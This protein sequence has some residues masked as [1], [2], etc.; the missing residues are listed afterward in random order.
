[1]AHF[2]LMT[3]GVSLLAKSFS[4]L[5]CT[6]SL[7]RCTSVHPVSFFLTS[8]G[9]TAQAGGPPKRP[10][11]GYMRYVV[12]QQPTIV[13]QNPA[14]KIT[15][16]IRKIAQEWRLMSAEQKRPFVEDFQ[17]ARDQFKL[18]LKR[19]EAKLTPAE[20]EQQAIE[21]KQVMAKRKEI[22]RKREMNSLGKP[23][24]PRS[25]FN[26]YMSEHFVEARG[27]TMP[28]KL[29]SLMDDWRSLLGYKKQVYMQLA[30]DDK[31]RYKNE[32][33]SWEEHMLEIG[34][35]D[36]LREQTRPKKAPAKKRATKKEVKAKP[37]AKKTA[38]AGVVKAAGKGKTAGKVTATRSKK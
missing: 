15:E 7:A 23:K 30:E 8:R 14:I 21:R 24:R 13:Q 26:I 1:M 18:D 33:K 9:L 27:L 17:R 10:L 20:F 25:A 35:E 16:V 3:A 12:Q 37:K 5:S 4:A 29:I 34:R 11:N 22:R 28:A 31:I 6:N 19:Y 36:L 2:N 32:I 38:T